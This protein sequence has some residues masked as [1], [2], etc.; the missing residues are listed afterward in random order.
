MRKSVLVLGAG[1]FI[2]R[3]IVAALVATD[4][5]RPIA[6][7]RGIR[8]A[9][10][11]DDVER[12]VLDATDQRALEDAIAT[13]PVVISSVAGEPDQIVRSGQ[14]LL[15]AVQGSRSPPRVVYLSSLSAYGS[16]TGTVSETAPLLGDVDSYSRAKAL[17][18]GLAAGFSTVTRLRPGVVYGPGSPW[19]SERIARLLVERRLGDLGEQGRGVCNLVHVDDVA[20]AV[21]RAAELPGAGGQAY[22]LGDPSPPTWNGYFEQYARA[23]G[24]APV[25]Q[26]SRTRLAAELYLFGPPLKVAERLLGKAN[27][28]R[29]HEAI[30]PWLLQLCRQDIRLQVDKAMA[31]LDLR[32]RP[33]QDGLEETAAWFR[34]GGRT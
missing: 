22:N 29:S 30:R 26:I 24:A 5:A 13:V 33:L 8:N 31:E 20:A 23:L 25:R 15:A 18:D 34:S 17:I 3:R 32:F 27:P 1:G 11:P 10:F 12:I 7:S 6:A 28:W 16:A 4:W 19:W 21:V 9:A 2:G 14:A